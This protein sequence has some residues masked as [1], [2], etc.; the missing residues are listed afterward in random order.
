MPTKQQ[1]VKTF[2][3]F[4]SDI[5][6]SSVRKNNWSWL[7]FLLIFRIEAI[8]V[9]WQRWCTLDW[10]MTVIIAPRF[11]LVFYCICFYLFVFISSICI[12]LYLCFGCVTTVM[13]SWR[14]DDGNHYTK[15]SSVLQTAIS[16]RHLSSSLWTSFCLYLYLY[17]YF[18]LHSYLHLQTTDSPRHLS[19]LS[20]SGH[21]HVGIFFSL[22]LNLCLQTAI[23]LHH[24]STLLSW[25]V[26]SS[27]QNA[28]IKKTHCH[29]GM[30]PSCNQ[31]PSLAKKVPTSIIEGAT[32]LDLFRHLHLQYGT[33]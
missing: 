8:L 30:F 5:K 13:H 4:N 1:F 7:L 9:A 11:L 26:S 12:S 16:L 19:T 31:M 29:P 3:S 20:S 6:I 15:I 32:F 18:H 10:L 14:I 21:H 23:C 33:L 28:I 24:S 27:Q 25:Y 17:L 2:C 22:F